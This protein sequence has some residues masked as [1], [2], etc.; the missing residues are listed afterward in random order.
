MPFAADKFSDRVNSNSHTHRG[1]QG[2]KIGARCCDFSPAWVACF[3]PRANR[4]RTIVQ[5]SSR[6]VNLY[7]YRSA[8]IGSN[9]DAF[10]AG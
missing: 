9:L 5:S 7:S 2:W 10:H 4:F 6:L 8:S 1:V 3:A